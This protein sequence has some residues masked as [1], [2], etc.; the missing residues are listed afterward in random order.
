MFKFVTI[1][2]GRFEKQLISPRALWKKM[3]TSFFACVE[4]ARTAATASDPFWPRRLRKK[5]SWTHFTKPSTETNIIVR[6][7]VVSLRNRPTSP[8]VPQFVRVAVSP[9]SSC[10][11]WNTPGPTLVVGAIQD[12]PPDPADRMAEPIHSTPQTFPKRG[13]NHRRISAILFRPRSGTFIFVFVIECDCNFSKFKKF[14]P[15][16]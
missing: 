12:V 7:V 2:T 15:S 4:N 11:R 5:H 10:L 1:N 3:E 14:H 8:K 6:V 13:I 16:I 9:Q